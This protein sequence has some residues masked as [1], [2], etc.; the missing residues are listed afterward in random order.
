MTWITLLAPTGSTPPT[1]DRVEHYA[2]AFT[3]TPEHCFRMIQ[4]ES[5]GVGS[6]MGPV[7]GTPSRRVTVTGP[8]STRFSGLAEGAGLD[9][10]VAIIRHFDGRVSSRFI[11]CFGPLQAS[12][13]DK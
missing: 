7:S 5:G 10:R 3:L 11:D 4:A 2:E 6:R 9:S 1:P 13:L 12:S 8:T